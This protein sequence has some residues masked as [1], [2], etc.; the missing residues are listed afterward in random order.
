MSNQDES[1]NS[2]NRILI[3]I[4]HVGWLLRR[5]HPEV[6]SKSHAVDMSD[7]TND[8][9]VRFQSQHYWLLYFFIAFAVPIAIPVYA[10]SETWFNSL[11]ISYFL[12]YLTSLHCTW[13]VNST[14][15]M[16]GDRPYNSNIQPVENHFVSFCTFGEGYHNYHHTFP[17]DYATSELPYTLNVSRR[18]IEF[19]H[20]IGLANNLKRPSDAVISARKQNVL[21][22]EAKLEINRCSPL[23]ASQLDSG[24]EADE[25]DQEEVIY[26]IDSKSL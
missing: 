24:Y 14:A 10:W 16:F 11:F 1:S 9:L 17:M 4:R 15:H 22:A 18:F 5:K 26:N 3:T 8:P 6:K 19:C 20:R 13:F 7:L 12:R 25:E 21:D 23:I 2:F